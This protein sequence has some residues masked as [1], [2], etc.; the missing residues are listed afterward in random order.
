MC[1]EFISVGLLQLIGIGKGIVFFDDFDQIEL[2]I[3]IGYNLGINYLWM[4]GILYELFCCGVL[5]IVFNL[6]CEW[7]L[8]C[9]VD[10][11]NVMEMVIWCLMLIVL[12]YYQVWVGGDVVVLKGIVKVLLQL[13]EEQGNVFDYVF[14]V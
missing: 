11:Q 6:L 7:V 5:I 2:V 13:E 1:Y 3:F 10:L 12:I 9:F 8:E 4:M 14:I